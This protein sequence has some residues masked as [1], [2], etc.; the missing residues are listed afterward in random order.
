MKHLSASFTKLLTVAA[1]AL[2]LSGCGRSEYAMLPKTSSYHG[3]ARVSAPV[4][5]APAA[6]A[7][8]A[9][10]ETTVVAVVPTA[11]P[12]TTSPV[13]AK[14]ASAPVTTAQATQVTP[15]NAAVVTPTAPR[16]LNLVQRL[17]VAKITHKLEKASQ[18]AAFNR[19]SNTASTQRLDGK[20]RQGLILLV[21]GLLIGIVGGAVGGTIGGVIALLGLI[22][23]IIGVV[24]I[25]LY[26]LDSL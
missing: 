1:C 22:F 5:V 16:K 12:K 2:T 26:L 10:P 15:A 11:A 13:A 24:L 3:V 20:L 6:A 7:A 4:P 18:K 8:V 21:V 9:A 17:A 14:A 19:H 25:I 23:V